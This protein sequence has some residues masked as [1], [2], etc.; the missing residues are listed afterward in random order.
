MLQD[1]QRFPDFATLR[2]RYIR[3]L[4]PWGDFRDI[5]KSPFC[6]GYITIFLKHFR[7]RSI[8][9]SRRHIRM[10]NITTYDTISSRN[11][12]IKQFSNVC[13][14]VCVNV[15]V[16][17]VCVRSWYDALALSYANWLAELIIIFSTRNNTPDV[18]RYFRLPITLSIYNRDNRAVWDWDENSGERRRILQIK[19]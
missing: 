9:H 17:V 7:F 18:R 16:C 14:Y 10:I 3:K 12:Y 2:S 6:K 19:Q 15:Y 11:S 4:F 8:P 1:L 13:T 5:V